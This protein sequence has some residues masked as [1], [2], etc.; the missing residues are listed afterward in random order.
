MRAVTSVRDEAGARGQVARL[1]RRLFHTPEHPDRGFYRAVA[2]V[3]GL[4]LL[5]SAVGAWAVLQASAWSTQGLVRLG[6]GLVLGPLVV[7][8]ALRALV[9]RWWQGPPPPGRHTQD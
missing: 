3:A 7:L 8:V 5:W 9:R 1:F 2:V 4:G 6:A